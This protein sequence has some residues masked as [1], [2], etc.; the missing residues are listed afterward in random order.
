VTS[1]L[2]AI[3]LGTGALGAL[4]G[5]SDQSASTL[6]PT[7][8]GKVRFG[9]AKVHTVADLS[10][11]FGAPS[12]R[13]QNTGCGP[14]YS[15]VEWGDL[16]AEFR[17]GRFS[18][19]RYAKGGFPL[20]TPGSPHDSSPPTGG[21]P[22]LATA[23][24]ITLGSTLAQLRAAYGALRLIGT[25]RWRSAEGLVFVDSAKAPA[26]PIVEIKIGTCGDF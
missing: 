16:I 5:Q 24:G 13:G 15:E 19:F 1:V 23:K 12:A 22:K 17:L 9:L 18:G 26:K 4:A 11:L 21:S 7:G 25:D 14:R 20:T 10:A 6:G 8:I 2:I 3:G